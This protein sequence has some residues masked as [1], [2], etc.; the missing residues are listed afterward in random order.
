L[1]GLTQDFEYHASGAAGAAVIVQPNFEVVF[2]AP[3][4]RAEATIGRFAERIRRNVGVLFRITRG[5]IHSAA[6]AG[7]TA[8][9]AL[10]ALN[11]VSARPIPANV[12]TDRRFNPPPRS[13]KRV[14]GEWMEASARLG[15]G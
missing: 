1:L 8:D 2:T 5:S 13:R 6:A 14:G 4:P 15:D 7:L 11:E 10:A 3:A 12:T 9:H